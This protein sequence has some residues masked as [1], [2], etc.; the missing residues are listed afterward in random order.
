MRQS[1]HSP[2]R[3]FSSRLAVALTLVLGTLGASAADVAAQTATRTPTPTPTP[4]LVRVEVSP[5]AVTRKVGEFASFSVKGFFSDGSDKNYTQ[6]VVYH[7]SNLAVA[8]PPNLEGNRGRV[9]AVGIGSSTI[10]VT[11]PGTGINSDASGG[12]AILTVVEAPTP[13]STA[14]TPTRTRTPTPTATSTPILV[15]LSISPLTPKRKV[16]ES[17]NF[18]VQGQYSDGSTKSLTQVVTYSSS[19]T[20]VAETPNEAGNKSR[21]LAV[22]PGFATIKATH[23]SGVTTTNTGG[24]A[25]FEVVVAPTPTATRTGATP[26]RTVTPLP[27]ATSTP[28]VVSVALNPASAR[29]G[30]GGSQNFSAIATFSDGSTKNITSRSTYT[31]SNPDVA[32]AGTDPFNPS[33]VLAVGVGTATISALDTV[34]NI[35][36][37]A[38]GGDATLEVFLAPTPTPSSTAATPTRTRTPTPTPTSTP[39]LVSLVISPTTV[40]KAVGGFQNFSV[41][42]NYN[43]GSQ[44]TFTQ[45]VEYQAS[46][47]DIVEFYTDPMNKGKVVALKP[48]VVIITAKDPVTGLTI[49]TNEGAEFTVTIAPTPTPTYTGPTHTGPT[50]TP[51]LTASPTPSPT[52]KLVKIELKPKTAQKQVGTPQFFTATGTFSDGSTKNVTQR[53]KYSSSD[54]SVASAPNVEGNRGQ[55]LTLEAGTTTI[56]AFDEATEVS[57]TTTGGDGVLTVVTGDGGGGGGTPR[58]GVTATPLPVQP[59]NPTTV[60]QKN[61]RRAART[62]VDKKMKVLDRCG[63]AASRCVQRK[64]NDPVCLEKIRAR[65]TTAL[66]KLANDEAK[67]I[68]NVLRRCAALGPNE[69]FGSNGLGYN[70]VATSC[71]EL[72]DRSLSDLSSVAQCLAAQHDCRAETLLSL[73]RPRTGEL[74]RI[75]GA[76]SDAGS[77]RED[78]GGSGSGVGDPTGLGKAVERCVQTLVRGGANL[79]KTRLGSIGGCIDA[80]FV[81]VEADGGNAACLTAATERC[82]KDFARVNQQIAKLTLAAGKACSGLDFTLLAGPTGAYLDAITPDCESFG[83]T[84]VTT[85]A[86]YVACLVRRNECEVADLIRYESPRADALLEEVDRALV[87]GSCP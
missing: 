87:D 40:K 58:P 19:N 61:L 54:P 50:G 34:T 27:T 62:Y 17:Q 6:K 85:V 12:S 36:T 41:K 80:V 44:K 10:S 43:D 35:S 31:S 60:C 53:V 86:D 24:D 14:P 83:V 72:F 49:P 16:G 64:P 28:V 57:S 74:L 67:F 5:R 77:C 68:A 23:A 78:F 65:C 1:P 52:P 76:T 73:V 55:I 32:A 42:G 70:E 63:S 45:K 30:L 81:C 25:T 33:K 11:E 48:G 18:T 75:L 46:K 22:G 69:L 4:Q 3:R 37:T 15:S 79:T 38:S 29:R 82:A 13:T 2:P 7:S 8:F 84:E 26:T 21:V 71:E 51:T 47:P 59:G 39:V 56:S 20:A 9:D 66:G